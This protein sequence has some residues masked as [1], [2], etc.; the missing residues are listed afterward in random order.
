ML[1]ITR[2]GT[3]TTSDHTVPEK[4]FRLIYDFKIPYSILLMH[5]THVSPISERHQ[6]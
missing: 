1:T 3:R 6:A 4:M 5:H 2:R